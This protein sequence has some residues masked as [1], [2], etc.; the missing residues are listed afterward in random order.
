MANNILSVA[1][2]NAILDD[3]AGRT[4]SHTPVTLTTS[5]IIGEETLTDGTPVNIKCYVMKTGQNFDFKQQGFVEE[6]DVIA[7]CKI[8]DS[9]GVNDKITINSEVFRVKEKYDVPG[10]FDS[11][12]TA[13]Y[14]YTVANLFL[15][16]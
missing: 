2:F 6:G 9:V 16:S 4:L 1:D 7:L 8:S 10:V 14:V 5:N 3:Y 11:S 12:T 13:T 15:I